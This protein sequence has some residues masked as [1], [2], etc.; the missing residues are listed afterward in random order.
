VTLA[1]VVVPSPT[2]RGL[3]PPPDVNPEISTKEP[4]LLFK[5]SVPVPLLYVPPVTVPVNP[6]IVTTPPS[7]SNKSKDVVAEK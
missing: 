3:P 6:V 5:V 4:S 2:L 7:L 1:T